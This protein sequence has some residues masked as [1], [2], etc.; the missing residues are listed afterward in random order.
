MR[1]L[2]FLLALILTCACGAAPEPTAATTAPLYVDAVGGGHG[3][4]PC[5]GP[6]PGRGYVDLFDGSRLRDLPA[7]TVDVAVHAAAGVPVR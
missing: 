3:P 7:G 5:V 4:F 6:T 1:R 2:K